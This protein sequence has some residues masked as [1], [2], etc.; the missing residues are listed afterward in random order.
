MRPELRAGNELVQ[1]AHHLAA[2]AHA[3]R[4]RVVALE[5]RRELVARARVEQNGFRPALARA[6][7]VAVG[8]SAARGEALR[9]RQADVRPAMMS[10]MWTSTASKPARSNAAAISIWPL[11]P[12]SRRIATRGARRRDGRRGD[13]ARQNRK[14]VAGASRGSAASSMRSNSSLRAV[15]IVAQRCMRDRSVP[16][17]RAAGPRGFAIDLLRRADARQI[18]RCDGSCRC[19]MTSAEAGAR[20]SV[21]NCVEIGSPRPAARRRALR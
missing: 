18:G 20:E 5:E 9:I 1:V 16:T 2:V 12:C 21:S 8:E 13:V 6:E 4:E 17:T 3:E 14:S 19:H 15:R 11:T 10:L 7:H